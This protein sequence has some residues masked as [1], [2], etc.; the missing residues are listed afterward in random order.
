MFSIFVKIYCDLY[1]RIGKNQ[2]KFKSMT[3]VKKRN[4]M[5]DI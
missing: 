5:V 2:N 4:T 3:F 1:S